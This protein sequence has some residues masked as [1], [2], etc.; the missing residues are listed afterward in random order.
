MMPGTEPFSLA[1]PAFALDP[2]SEDAPNEQIK[3]QIQ[4]LVTQIEQM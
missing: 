2:D 3:Q 1:V 4:Q